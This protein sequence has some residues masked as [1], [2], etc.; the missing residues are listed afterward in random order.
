MIS[1]SYILPPTSIRLRFA[2]CT[3]ER[4]KYVFE[5]ALP[6]AV[7]CCFTSSSLMSINRGS[8][9]LGCWSAW[10][11]YQINRCGLVG[12]LITVSGIQKSYIKK[13]LSDTIFRLSTTR[14]FVL[15][16]L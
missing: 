7:A 4:V 15:H 16:G 2:R 8:K 3:E 13:I 1:S 6:S 11:D 5:G 10:A 12:I 9:L 14:V